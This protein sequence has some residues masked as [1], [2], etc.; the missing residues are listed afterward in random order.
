ME[1]EQIS[2]YFCDF[3]I[4]WPVS[5]H[6]NCLLTGLVIKGLLM[7]LPADGQI[8]SS[9]PFRLKDFHITLVFRNLTDR[10]MAC[11]F[12]TDFFFFHLLA[13]I[14][15]SLKNQRLSSVI[16]L[17]LCRI[18]RFLSNRDKVEAVRLGNLWGITL[19]FEKWGEMIQK[20]P[21]PRAK[22]VGST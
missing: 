8:P 20:T 4:L 21:V 7:P 18:S 19:K 2:E 5:N 9:F 17:N 15:L 13:E 16:W 14:L 3:D 6:L 10:P 22:P 1:R 11:Q 12:P